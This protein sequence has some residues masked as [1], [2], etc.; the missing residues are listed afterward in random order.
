MTPT[1]WA[2]R[3]CRGKNPTGGIPNHRF[4]GYR[5]KGLCRR[6]EAR[7]RMNPERKLWGEDVARKAP[8]VKGESPKR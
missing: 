8:R 3:R 4:G 5:S 6:A 7:E 2:G 1:H